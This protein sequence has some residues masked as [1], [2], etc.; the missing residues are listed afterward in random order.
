MVAMVTMFTISALSATFLLTIHRS[1]DA[2]RRDRHGDA[3]QALALAGVNKAMAALA[4]D[5]AYAGERDTVL[6]EGAFSVTVERFD[7]GF[8]VESTGR[9]AD[10]AHEISA[11][12][13]RAVV[14]RARGGGLRLDR[15]ERLRRQAHVQESE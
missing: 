1:L 7:E 5:A 14:V 10:W 4:A 13:L 3:A 9:L 15:A 2:E 8:R 11:V 12:T 6:G